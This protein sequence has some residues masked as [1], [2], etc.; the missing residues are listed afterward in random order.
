ML[1]ANEYLVNLLAGL[2]HLRIFKFDIGEEWPLR[3]QFTMKVS[4]RV[5][6][7]E[8]FHMRPHY[9]K[10]IGGKLVECDET[11]HYSFKL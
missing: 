4:D 8:Y 6:H 3:D 1:D 10:R 11:E 9:Y 5:P 2:V 7:L